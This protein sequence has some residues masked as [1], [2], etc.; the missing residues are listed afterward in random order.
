[1][2]QAGRLRYIPEAQKTI[3]IGDMTQVSLLSK[4]DQ[5]SAIHSS[6]VLSVS[7][8]SLVPTHSPFGPTSGCSFSPLPRCSIV[9][10]S[11]NLF[12][13]AIQL[14]TEFALHLSQ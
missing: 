1:M 9:V 4:A 11:S 14:G 10:N 5:S 13:S 3:A 12:P 2:P 8:D 7:F 6:S